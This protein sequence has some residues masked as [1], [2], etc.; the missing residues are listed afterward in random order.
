MRPSVDQPLRQALARNPVVVGIQAVAVFCWPAT[1][2][3]KS[4]RFSMRGEVVAIDV[5][6][7]A[8]CATPTAA[9]ARALLLAGSPLVLRLLLA[10]LLAGQ[11]DS[12]R[13]HGCEPG[14]GQ[15]DSTTGA[16]QGQGLGRGS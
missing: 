11:G 5:A 14:R 13:G 6:R 15:Q 8:G 3:E 4:L 7:W 1:L 10:L 2:L 16:E 9:L 12:I